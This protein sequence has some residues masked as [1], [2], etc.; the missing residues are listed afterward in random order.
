MKKVFLVLPNLTIGGAEKVY[1]EIIN[2][3]NLKKFKIYLV[4]FCHNDNVLKKDIK[5]KVETIFLNKKTVKSGIFSFLKVINKIKPDVL[6]SSIIH[7][8]ILIAILK[9]FFPN[10]TKII[11]RNSNYY[12][13]IIKLSKYSFL[14]NILYQIFIKRFDFYIFISQEQKKDFLTHFKIP[15]DKTKVINN[16]LNFRQIIKKSNALINLDLFSK[17]GKTLVVCGSYKY[18][19]GFDLLI[20]AINLI[21]ENNPRVLIIGGGIKSR[22]NQIKKRIKYLDLEKQIFMIGRKENVFPYFKNSDAIVIPSRFEG[23]CNVLI[24]ALCLNKPI[25]CTPAPG[26]AKELIKNSTGVFMAKNISS[27]ALASSIKDFIYSKK[28]ISYSKNI[29]KADIH[30]GIKEYEQIFLKV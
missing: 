4:I 7:L 15:L 2:N 21:R 19:K 13:E 30:F 14:M 11:C 24:E 10:K 1:V 27:E 18:Q 25:I 16:P 28:K 12:S 6:M 17:N 23:C 22:I 5:S 26:L 9:P 29:Y 8:N 3:I 20:D